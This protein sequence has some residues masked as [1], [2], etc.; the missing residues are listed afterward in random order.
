MLKEKLDLTLKKSIV[1]EIHEFA[2]EKGLERIKSLSCHNPEKVAKVLY[3]YSQGVSQTQLHTRHN[4]SHR[5]TQ[6]ILV[7]YAGMFLAVLV[8][9]YGMYLVGGKC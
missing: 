8:A 6:K 3:L 9:V 2:K 5:T 1:E 7:D 4:I